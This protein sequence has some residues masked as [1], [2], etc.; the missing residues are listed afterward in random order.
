MKA[1]KDRKNGKS[2]TKKILDEK[3][4]KNTKKQRQPVNTQME[5]LKL[6]L[7]EQTHTRYNLRAANLLEYLCAYFSSLFFFFFAVKVGKT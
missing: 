3:E 2:H 7:N 5:K 6:E 4:K 1:Q